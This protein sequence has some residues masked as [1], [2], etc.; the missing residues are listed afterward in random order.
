MPKRVT[1][2]DVAKRA[3]VSRTTVSFV[4][5]GRD[6]AIPEETR[7]RVRAA[8]DDLGYVPSAAARAL[9]KGVSDII[10]VLSAGGS[11]ADL[12]DYMWESFARAF[13]ARG[14]TTVFSRTAGTATP[15]QALLE[16]L[17]PRAIVS[18]VELDE[19]DTELVER[20][21]IPL[22]SPSAAQYTF[23][24]LQALMGTTQASYLLDHGYRRLIYV[25]DTRAQRFRIP[26]EQRRVSFTQA[27]EAHP[28][29]ALLGTVECDARSPSAVTDLI[30][31]LSDVV[32]RADA[33]GTFNDDAAAVTLSA[34]HRLG[35]AVPDD[36]AVIG[37]D[38]LTLSRYLSPPLTT[39]AINE[40]DVW[41]EHIVSSVIALLNGASP[42]SVSDPSLGVRVI[43]REST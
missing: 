1:A 13:Q 18:L 16:E 27:V 4:L 3:G 12:S 41:S 30:E 29:A 19:Q 25:T 42:P 34:L 37:V 43:E 31:A 24:G 28:E 15:L 32:G 10:L 2:Q 40:S 23:S 17:R 7:E 9:R 14:L 6:A 5:N 8:A 26:L 22:L 36:V 33:I 39:L 20:L 21:D 35:L 11:A 38:D